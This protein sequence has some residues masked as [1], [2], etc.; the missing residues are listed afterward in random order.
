MNYKIKIYKKSGYTSH[1]D[2]DED[3][4]T[5]KNVTAS[6]RMNKSI[7]TC[8]SEATIVM[9]YEKLPLAEYQGGNKGI[10]DNYAKIEIYIDD[11]VQFTGVIKKYDYDEENKTISLL[12]HDMYYKL[13]NLTDKPLEYTNAL[14]TEIIKDLATKAGCS[15]SR[16]GGIDYTVEHIKI[17]ADT[18]YSDI[19][20][21][22]CETIHARVR[23]A[24]DGTILLEEQYPNYIEG[25]GDLNHFDWHYQDFKNISTGQA[26]RD[27]TEM[28][29]V[30]KII[31]NNRYSTYE[32]PQVTSY[33]NGEKVRD[34]VENAVADLEYKRRSVAGYTFLTKWR[35]ST[36]LTIGITNG[37]PDLDL[38]QVIKT[39]LNNRIGY[40]LAIGITTEI[41]PDAYIDTIQLE[42]L[43][44]KTTAYDL[45]ELI[46][47]GVVNPDEDEQPEP[48]KV[49]A[50]EE[51]KMQIYTG[52]SSS[53]GF[54]DI[55]YVDIIP[56]TVGWQVSMKCLESF[57][58]D[59]VDWGYTYPDLV[60]FDPNGVEYG[61]YGKVAPFYPE[62]LQPNEDGTYPSPPERER[63]MDY[64]EN[65]SLSS[66]SKMSYS[67]TEHN[68]EE[69][70]VYD[71]MPGRWR[72]K[73]YSYV[74][75]SEGEEKPIIIKSNVSW[76]VV[77]KEGIFEI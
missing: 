54:N 24:K 21:E 16:L 17:D 42:G 69:W 4:L 73:A 61:H 40:Y 39:E 14:A 41:D 64:C 31:C 6:I 8:T 55:G 74:D 46:E 67:G 62:P 50:D 18:M 25:G 49:K 22:Y 53:V 9:P 58:S 37:N 3:I 51:L 70:K 2:K 1:S 75:V 56:G 43:R 38:G 68:P 44:D 52:T 11:K 34:V 47:Q 45:P 36:K 7:D 71:P 10:I 33:L 28:K 23:A 32:E 13:L 72:I 48:E 30:L 60:I 59:T 66:C 63:N 76:V 20:Q 77:N 5:I 26:S 15:F 29:S 12:C 65:T 57:Q 27:A 19:I 35:H